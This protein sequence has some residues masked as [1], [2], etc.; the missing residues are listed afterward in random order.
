MIIE[1]GGV[2]ILKSLQE[3]PVVHPSVS[4]ICKEILSIVNEHS[5]SSVLQAQLLL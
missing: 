3:N 5:D 2:Q 4:A 1:E